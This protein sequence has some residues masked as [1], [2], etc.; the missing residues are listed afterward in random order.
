MRLARL[1][2]LLQPKQRRA[3]MMKAAKRRA[4]SAAAKL[5]VE[6]E[7]TLLFAYRSLK[8]GTVWLVKQ[9][10]AHL[11]D[12]DRK[13]EERIMKRARA[14]AEGDYEAIAQEQ[15]K[16]GELCIEHKA[17][18]DS[19]LFF[20]VIGGAASLGG[21]MRAVFRETD[22]DG[23]EQQIRNALKHEL[24][25]LRQA[26]WPRPGRQGECKGEEGAAR[27]DGALQPPPEHAMLAAEQDKLRAELQSVIALQRWTCGAALLG[28]AASLV[29]AAC[30]RR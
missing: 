7:G 5:Q 13:I 1:S 29:A 27:G 17:R 4:T 28:C 22:D 6:E 18:L 20:W 14:R 19:M 23:T 2:W 12:L 24:S 21:W 10:D 9:A 11:C 3:E 25:E 26:I 15:N 8:R 16:L 30:S